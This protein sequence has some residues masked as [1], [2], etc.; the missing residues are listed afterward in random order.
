MEKQRGEQLEALSP[1]L[2]TGYTV[3]KESEVFRKGF[4]LHP[5]LL[6]G[7]HFGIPPPLLPARLTLLSVPDESRAEP[8]QTNP[9]KA[10]LFYAFKMDHRARSYSKEMNRD[11]ISDT[12]DGLTGSWLLTATPFSGVQASLL[13]STSRLQVLGRRDRG[14]EADPGPH[15]KDYLQHA[16][17]QERASTHLETNS[18]AR[19]F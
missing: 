3:A 1:P 13:L 2:T 17:K 4:R 12:H 6:Q 19:C 7:G 11:E 10:F 9:L 5:L 18:Q 15:S 8:G 14:R 16:A